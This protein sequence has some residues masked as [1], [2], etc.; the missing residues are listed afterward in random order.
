MGM[1]YIKRHFRKQLADAV[2]Q[3]AKARSDAED[4][5]MAWWERN[6]GPGQPI[7]QWPT[8]PYPDEYW[9]ALQQLRQAKL[10]ASNA[11]RIDAIG[12]RPRDRDFILQPGQEPSWGNR[13]YG[14]F[15]PPVHPSLQR[16]QASQRSMANSKVRYWQ[17]KL[18]AVRKK[19]GLKKLAFFKP[20]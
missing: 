18:A 13:V 1:A 10:I 5:F 12:Y 8:L 6:P 20:R 14:E 9:K 19:F 17:T 7:H 11:G 15:T 3:R 4:M 2:Q 16:W